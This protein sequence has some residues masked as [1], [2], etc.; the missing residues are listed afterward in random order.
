ML[1]HLI[2]M[3]AASVASA[4]SDARDHRQETMHH[5][6]ILMPAASAAELSWTCTFTVL[7]ASR[8]FVITESLCQPR[9]ILVYHWVSTI[10]AFATR[11]RFAVET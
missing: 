11:R 1:H 4:L 7:A 3:P 8:R 2:L 9:L 10:N 5:R 6:R